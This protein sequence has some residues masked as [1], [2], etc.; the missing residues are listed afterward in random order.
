MLLQK[1]FVKNLIFGPDFNNS[2]LLML[3]IVFAFQLFACWIFLCFLSSADFVKIA[4]WVKLLKEY[5]PS[6]K[7]IGP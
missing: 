3:R 5:D 2:I 6:T 7:H 1:Q 4:F